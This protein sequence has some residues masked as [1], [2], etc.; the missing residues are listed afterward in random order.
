MSS[1]PPGYGPYS[2]TSPH[3]PPSQYYKYGPPLQEMEAN[4]TVELPAD[5][6]G[7]KPDATAFK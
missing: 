7:R 2:G 4:H 5:S 1:Q 6:Q 3:S